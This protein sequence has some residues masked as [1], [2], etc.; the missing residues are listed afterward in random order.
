MSPRPGRSKSPPGGLPHAVAFGINASRNLIVQATGS[1]MVVLTGLI[2]FP[3]QLVVAWAAAMVSVATLEHQLLRVVAR[4]GRYAARAARG[5]PIL[6]VLATTLYAVAALFLVAKGGGG[7]RMFAFALICASMVHVLMRYYRTRWILLASLAPHVTVL[8][9]IAV[10]H[11][12]IALAA[13]AC[14]S[15]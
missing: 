5:A 15:W 8:E 11:A 3:W 9:L 2:V 4:G 7:E 10:L 6:R 1:A 12:K 14:S 13:S